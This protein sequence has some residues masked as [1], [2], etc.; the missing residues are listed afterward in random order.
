M[1]LEINPVLRTIIPPL[2]TDEYRD[3]EES[4]RTEGCRDALVIWGETIVDGHNRYEICTKHCVPFNTVSKDFSDLEE[5]KTWIIRNQFGRRNLS[6]QQRCELALSLQDI[7]RAKAKERQQGGKGGV[8]LHQ[9]VGEASAKG[10]TD[11]ELAKIA[12]VSHSTIHQARVI[13]NEG[14]TEQKQRLNTGQASI[15]GVYHEIR[16]PDRVG[17]TAP[18]QK[19][20]APPVQVQPCQQG[21]DFRYPDAEHVRPD[22]QRF[23]TVVKGFLGEM[24]NYRFLDYTAISSEEVSSCLFQID[25]IMDELK[26]IKNLIAK[27]GYES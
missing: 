11:R 22:I 19:A 18:E 12:G 21:S 25:I 14:T 20:P 8:L 10:T 26:E 5:A 9:L 17:G 16:H 24:N 23:I 3:L 1:T 27:R 2:T 6:A 4:I 7:I 13:K 15:H